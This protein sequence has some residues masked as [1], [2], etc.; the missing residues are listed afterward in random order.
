MK[1]VVTGDTHMPK[2]AKQL[3]PR[4]IQECKTA[5]LIIH[6]GDWSS[7]DVY[8]ELSDCGYVRGVYGNIDDE[9][10]REYLPEQDLMILNGFSIGLVHGHGQKKTTEKRAME[11][12]DDEQPDII[13]FGHSHIPMTR[14][15]K[16]QL[17]LNPGSPTDKRA[18]PYY[19]FAILTLSKEIHTEMIYFSHYNG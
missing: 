12:F 17:L 18:L 6:T 7:M 9:D 13:L 1:I 5:D 10:I 11:T 8:R 4:L 15:F 2:K 14:Y 19:S 3:P 16:K